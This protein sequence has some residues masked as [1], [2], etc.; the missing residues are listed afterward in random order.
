MRVEKR[1]DLFNRKEERL[2]ASEDDLISSRDETEEIKRK[3]GHLAGPSEIAKAYK[4]INRNSNQW[5]LATMTMGFG[6][7]FDTVIHLVEEAM[8]EDNF[9][10]EE[11]KEERIKWKEK[12]GL[13]G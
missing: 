10:E 5:W 9:T 4:Q 6:A 13:E 2:P 8:K 7:S 12:F 11:K 3:Y 1:E